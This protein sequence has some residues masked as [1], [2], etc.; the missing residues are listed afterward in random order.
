MQK[1]SVENFIKQ[2]ESY[3]KDR[4]APEAIV[5]EVTNAC[6]WAKCAHCYMMACSPSEGIYIDKKYISE[7]IGYLAKHKKKPKEFW[8]TGGEPTT[9]KDIIEILQKIKEEGF[10]SIL[11]SRGNIF[12][13]NK[14]TNILEQ[15]DELQ[16][17]VR[18]FSSLHDI[19]MLPGDDPMWDLVDRN[20]E[21][22]AQIDKL[23]ENLPAGFAPRR[24]D[25]LVK[26]LQSVSSNKSAKISLNIDVHAHTD[27]LEIIKA[28]SKSG[29]NVYNIE[30]QV[31]QL[32]GRAE[33]Y[34]D[35][36]ANI[37]RTATKEI[38]EKYFEMADIIEKEGLIDNRIRMIDKVPEEIEQELDLLKGRWQKF[39][40]PC[41]VPA[42][43]YNGELIVDVVRT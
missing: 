43:N 7:I 30:I 15:L 5:L 3:S 37:W 22:K 4:N 23:L 6:S 38:I 18:G 41:N 25:R 20:S 33:F 13:D 26:S 34:K 27:L 31:M 39:Y 14:N 36:P 11:V 12:A 35:C 9:H 21:P 29:I 1:N 8:V 32:S 16:V 2:W 42:I 19:M 28:F 40:K 17:S 10:Y 24:W